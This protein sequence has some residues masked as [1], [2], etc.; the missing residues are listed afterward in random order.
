MPKLR[1]LLQ[2]RQIRKCS[3]GLCDAKNCKNRKCQTLQMLQLLLANTNPHPRP[4]SISWQRGAKTI[5]LMTMVQQVRQEWVTIW[6]N[7]W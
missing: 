5:T 3:L 1:K 4:L 6:K 7:I 2:L